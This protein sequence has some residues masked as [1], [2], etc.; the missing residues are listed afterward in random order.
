MW[1]DLETDI[2]EELGDNAR[3]ERWGIGSVTRTLSFQDPHDDADSWLSA[4]PAERDAMAPRLE[5]KLGAFR[6]RTAL[7]LVRAARKV[8]VRPAAVQAARMREYRKKPAAK[9][10]DNARSAEWRKKNRERAA[11]YLREWRTRRSV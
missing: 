4:S 6:R 5:A 2:A 1:R 9:A 7:A 3:F 11:A 8:F 10:K